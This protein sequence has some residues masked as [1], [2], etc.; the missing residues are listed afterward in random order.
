M[1]TISELMEQQRSIKEDQKELMQQFRVE[2]KFK[3]VLTDKLK[4]NAKKLLEN[5][6]AINKHLAE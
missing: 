2:K 5:E 4:L 6:E 1:T 3:E